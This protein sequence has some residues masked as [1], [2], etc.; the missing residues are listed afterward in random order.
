MY[1]KDDI[2][3][4]YFQKR[5]LAGSKYQHHAA[6]AEKEFIWSTTAE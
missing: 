2:D 3:V 6:T 4:P 1:I 5:G